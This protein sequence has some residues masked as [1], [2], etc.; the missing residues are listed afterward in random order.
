[1]QTPYPLIEALTPHYGIVRGQ[2]DG[3]YQRVV[4]E[5]MQTAKLMST[6]RH[7]NVLHVIS[8]TTN[9][10]G[11]PTTIVLGPVTYTLPQYLRVCAARGGVS[12]DEAATLMQGL[13]S[14]VEAL[15]NH[16]TP[17]YRGLTMD[18]VFVV[19]ESD[20]EPLAARLVV[21]SIDCGDSAVSSAIID[22]FPL[23][24]FMLQ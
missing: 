7:P 2:G 4:A 3:V 15:H 23:K 10:H 18:N 17:V 11:D 1:M 20:T 22:F 12:V 5:V 24:L 21:G 16:S 13:L 9:E 8:V 14:G 6:V 19:Q